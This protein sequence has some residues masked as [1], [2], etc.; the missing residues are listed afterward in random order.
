MHDLLVL[1]IVLLVVTLGTIL[2]FRKSGKKK[3]KR[4]VARQLRELFYKADEE[5]PR[6]RRQFDIADLVQSLEEA[7]GG[8]RAKRWRFGQ[9]VR[10]K[11][12]KRVFV[13]FEGDPEGV[14]KRRRISR[15]VMVRQAS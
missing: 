5:K 7:S 13:Q 1:G 11:G 2:Y 4:P 3:G 15:L 12:A 14:V 9:V 8:N 6:P 10:T